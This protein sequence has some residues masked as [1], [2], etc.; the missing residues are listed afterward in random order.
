MAPDRRVH[1]DV[2]KWNH[3]PCYWPFVRGIHQWPV[4]SHHKRQW[5]GALMCLIYV[6]TN[7]WVNNGDVC[8]WRCYRAH[9]DVTVMYTNNYSDAIWVVGIRPLTMMPVMWNFGVFFVV[10]L[11]NCWTNVE[12][13]VI[14]HQHTRAISHVS[15]NMDLS[16]WQH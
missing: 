11:H 12:L 15:S 5:R 9:Y 1:D 16:V 13:L 4:N 14:W 3:F 8:D 6:W 2:I 7:S 10:S